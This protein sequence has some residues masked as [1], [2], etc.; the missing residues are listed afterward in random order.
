MREKY[1]KNVDQNNSEYEHFLRS[2]NVDVWL[3]L[4]NSSNKI[5]QVYLSMFSH[6]KRNVNQNKIGMKDFEIP[7]NCFFFLESLSY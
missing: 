6:T 4:L 1:G 2:D 3:E 5:L 7:V